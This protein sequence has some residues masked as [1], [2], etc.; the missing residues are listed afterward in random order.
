MFLLSFSKDIDKRRGPFFFKTHGQEHTETNPLTWQSE[1][2]Y[3]RVVTKRLVSTLILTI[4]SVIHHIRNLEEC[5]YWIIDLNLEI[6]YVITPQCVRSKYLY[7]LAIEVIVKIPLILYST[8][9][10]RKSLMNRKIYV[11]YL[12]YFK[13]IS[14]QPFSSIPV[15]V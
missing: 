4:H 5:R 14:R 2:L 6:I 7:G 3:F 1:I 10:K 12:R 9:V 11:N 15:S 8:S 13:P